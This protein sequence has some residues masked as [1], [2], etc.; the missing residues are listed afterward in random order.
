MNQQKQAIA[1]VLLAF[2][3]FT[4]ANECSS[5]LQGPGCHTLGSGLEMFAEAFTGFNTELDNVPDDAISENE[6]AQT[7]SSSALYIIKNVKYG[8]YLSV[9]EDIVVGGLSHV[10]QLNDEGNG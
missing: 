2:I 7:I 10:W 9:E 4:T 3:S 6:A 5:P 8:V 1:F